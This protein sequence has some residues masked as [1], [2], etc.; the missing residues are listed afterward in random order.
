MTE[1]NQSGEQA[2]PPPPP[3][4]EVTTTTT[5]PWRDPFTYVEVKGSQGDGV[6]RRD[7]RRK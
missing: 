7:I 4:K 2:P 5:T 1:P 6:E 3:P